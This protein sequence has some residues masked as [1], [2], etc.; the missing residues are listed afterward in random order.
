MITS[1]HITWGNISAHESWQLAVPTD[2]SVLTKCEK[3]HI[4]VETKNR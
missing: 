1:I 3:M 4:E 2:F